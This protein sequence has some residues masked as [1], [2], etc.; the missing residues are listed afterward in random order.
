MKCLIAGLPD[1]GKSTYL[2]ALWAIEKEGGTGHLMSISEYP[3][4][5][6]YLDR[7]KSKWMQLQTVD[8]TSLELPTEISLSFKMRDTEAELEVTV[9]DFKGEVF[10]A[11]LKGQEKDDLVRWCQDCDNIMFFMRISPDL[12]LQEQIQMGAAKINTQKEA[13]AFTASDIHPMV[14]NLLV[15]K[16]LLALSKPKKIAVCISAWDEAE[17]H[18]GENAESWAKNRLRILHDFLNYFFPR[19]KFFGVSAQGMKYDTDKEADIDEVDF[20]RRAY[21]FTQGNKSYDITEPLAY[22][23]ADD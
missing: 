21:V 14:R 12:F 11:I 15:L 8:R 3:A 7:L 22:L 19:V 10:D 23:A 20:K 13:K 1:A 16:R 17:L 6:T 5:T 9:P 4:D 2:A 18:E